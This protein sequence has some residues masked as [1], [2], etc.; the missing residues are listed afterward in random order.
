VLE[1]AGEV[2]NEDW[3]PPIGWEDAPK[4]LRVRWTVFRT[5]GLNEAAKEKLSGVEKRSRVPAEIRVHVGDV[6]LGERAFVKD[7][8][9][10][11]AVLV[12]HEVYDRTNTRVEA[13][14]KVPILP[15]N[16]AVDNLVAGA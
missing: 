6:H 16:L 9:Q 15:L 3:G 10:T 2:A 7:G 11:A 4:V 5:N 1:E 14:A 8:A 13:E 12:A